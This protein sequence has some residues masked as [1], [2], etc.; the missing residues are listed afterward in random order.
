MSDSPHATVTVLLN[1]G[2]RSN[3]GWEN[4]AHITLSRP[5]IE[6]LMGHIE[7]FERLKAEVA[8]VRSIEIDETRMRFFHQDPSIVDETTDDEDLRM[9]LGAMAEQDEFGPLFVH[10][11]ALDLRVMNERPTTGSTLRVMDGRVRWEIEGGRA[12][13][14]FLERSDL[15]T[16]LLL[17]VPVAERT[18][19]F[20]DLAREDPKKAVRLLEPEYQPL[21]GGS[22]EPFDFNVS[23]AAVQALLASD[24]REIRRIAIATIERLGDP[25][26]MGEGPAAPAGHAHRPDPR[27]R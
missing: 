5:D 27:A 17:L 23:P 14:W 21:L 26:V 4:L 13:S 25:E 1:L 16:G 22:G 11:D 2:F 6:E 7:R 8:G 12:E 9:Y 18:E 20:A 19:V 15:L 24:D 10:P 3:T